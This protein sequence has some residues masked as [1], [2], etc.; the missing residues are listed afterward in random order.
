MFVYCTVLN[1]SI[2]QNTQ[3]GYTKVRNDLDQTVNGGV[4]TVLE[5]LDKYIFDREHLVQ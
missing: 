4:N 3:E 2:Q 1:R 5:N